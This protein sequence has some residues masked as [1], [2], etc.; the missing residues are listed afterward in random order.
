MNSS[1]LKGSAVLVAIGAAQVIETVKNSA[2]KRVATPWRTEGAGLAQQNILG[3]YVRGKHMSVNFDR[4]SAIG[5]LI[6]AKFLVSSR[7]SE[8]E[9]QVPCGF[10]DVRF[11]P[12]LCKNARDLDVNGTVRHF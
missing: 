3:P 8:T 10:S 4:R 11:W 2:K 7:N 12:R 1:V 6:I 9:F 5:F